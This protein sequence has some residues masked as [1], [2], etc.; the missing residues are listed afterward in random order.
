MDKGLYLPKLAGGN[1]TTNLTDIHGVKEGYGVISNKATA[2]SENFFLF[3]SLLVNSCLH[4]NRVRKAPDYCN[5]LIAPH[6]WSKGKKF[7]KYIN[8][9]AIWPVEYKKDFIFSHVVTFTKE[10]DQCNKVY[11]F[12]KK[13][14]LSSSFRVKIDKDM[15]S[16]NILKVPID[17][18]YVCVCG[19]TI[20][21][22]KD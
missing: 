18:E 19:N 16:Q 22:K 3:F 13:P 10:C 1:I 11:Q 21:W 15:S 12:Y 17:G 5:Y 8:P 9:D 6:I 2:D 4:Q 14:P 20:S 7:T